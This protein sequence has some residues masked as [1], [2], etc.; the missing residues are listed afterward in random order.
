[1]SKKIVKYLLVFALLIFT[2]GIFSVIGL[3]NTQSENINTDIEAKADVDLS[4]ARNTND[5]V[6]DDV[7]RNTQSLTTVTKNASGT[8]QQRLAVNYTVKLIQN[9]AQLSE[10]AYKVNNGDSNE[11]TTN[12]VYFLTND[13]DLSG[14][15]WTP[16]G[17]AGKPFNA[18]F[19]G[20]GFTI[21]NIFINDL[22]VDSNA[23]SGS[24][25]FGNSTGVIANLKTSNVVDNSS[26]TKKSILC[27]VNNGKVVD[28][29]VN[30]T[31]T[32]TTVN[33]NGGNFKRGNNPWYEDTQL[34]LTNDSA[35]TA[36]FDYYQVFSNIKLREEAGL[37][38][39][40]PIRSGYKA[41]IPTSGNITWKATTINVTFYY[42][43]GAEGKA[44]NKSVDFGYDQTFYDWFS[45]HKGYNTRAG[46][47]VE[48]VYNTSTSG[49][50][51]NISDETDYKICY[52]EYA[53]NL[54]SDVYFTWTWANGTSTFTVEPIIAQT[55][56]DKITLSGAIKEFA[57][58]NND[59]KENPKEFSSDTATQTFEITL[60]NGYEIK[61]TNIQYSV[62]FDENNNN[63]VIVPSS[64]IYVNFST[65]TKEDPNYNS[66]GTNDNYNPISVSVSTVKK[67]DKTI[68]YTITVNNLVGGTANDFIYLAIQRR[69]VKVELID[70]YNE[71]SQ[72][73]RNI[74][75]NSG[76]IIVTY[77]NKTDTSSS[78]KTIEWS[79]TG[80]AGRFETEKDNN[81]N[82][83][84]YLV[85]KQNE[86]TKLKIESAGEN[87]YILSTDVTG[88]DTN[89][90]PSAVAEA[91]AI[92]NKVSGSALLGNS[93]E[94]DINTSSAYAD[95]ITEL[96]VNIGEAKTK[97]KTQ[98]YYGNAPINSFTGE[99]ANIS[100]KVN[101]S[102]D[103]QNTEA[104]VTR[105]T[106]EANDT[107]QFNANGFYQA[108][109]IVIYEGDAIGEEG[110]ITGTNPKSITFEPVSNNVLSQTNS[111]THHLTD[112]F[113]NE[114]TNYTIV[115]Y[116]E[117]R[118]YKITVTCETV[119][120]NNITSLFTQE[121]TGGAQTGVPSEAERT[122]TLTYKDTA[123]KILR[124]VDKDDGI[125]G[126]DK[127][128][129][130]KNT[131]SISANP[132]N[133]GSATISVKIGT[134]DANI[135]LKFEFKVVTINVS[136]TCLTSV[137]AGGLN[138]ETT[139]STDGLD[140]TT[141]GTYKFT[142]DKGKIGLDSEDPTK[143]TITSINLHSRYYAKGW[144]AG[145]TGGTLYNNDGFEIG[146]IPGLVDYIADKGLNNINRD[147]NVDDI[148]LEV[149]KRII[150]L[151][152]FSGKF[153]DPVVS[154]RG[155][156]STFVREDG[157]SVG[158][159]ESATII[160]QPPFK[161]L[162]HTFNG[163]KIII[164]NGGTTIYPNRTQAFADDNWYKVFELS[165]EYEEWTNF[166]YT[167][168][169]EK[170]LDIEALWN[171]I[172][173]KIQI[174]N[175]TAD[176][177][178]GQK[179][180]FGSGGDRNGVA[181]Y[182][183]EGQQIY[184]AEQAGYN[185]TSF[186]I[187][188]NTT[189]S[190]IT[191]YLFDV[192]NAKSLLKTVN[193]F[194][195]ND[196]D[197]IVITTNR[198]AA[199]FTITV[200]ATEEYYKLDGDCKNIQIAATFNEDVIIKLG[201]FTREGYTC[202]GLLYNGNQFGYMD[203]L[204]YQYKV[205]YTYTEDVF[206]YPTW[207][208]ISE[209]VESD[210]GMHEDAKGEVAFYMYNSL[211]V[212]KGGENPL[213]NT[214]VGKI[215]SNGEKITNLGFEITNH[216]GDTFKKE[217]TDILN[218]TDLTDSN[219]NIYA[220]EYKI[221]FFISVS[222]ILCKQSGENNDYVAES[223]EL[224]ITLIKNEL[225]FTGEFHSTY[226]GT[227]DF[228]VNEN[229]N[230]GA[231]YVKYGALGEFSEEERTLNEINPDLATKAYFKNFVILPK[232]EKFDAGVGYNIKA[233]FDKTLMGAY[234][235]GKNFEEL[236]SN[237]YAD[238]GNLYTIINGQTTIDKAK[239]TL[240]EVSS[241][242][243]YYFEGVEP[244]VYTNLQPHE[245]NIGNHTFAYSYDQIT[246]KS[247][248]DETLYGPGV[249][250]GSE[251]YQTDRQY[252]TIYNLK[253]KKLSDESFLDF[254]EVANNFEWNL[255]TSFSFTVIDSS[256]ETK[257]AKLVY[258]PKYILSENGEISDIL[259]DEFD[260]QKEILA[261]SDIKV[262]ATPVNNVGQSQFTYSVGNQV[263][264]SYVDNNT[265]RFSIY[266]NKEALTGN[267]LTFK[268]NVINRRN[269]LTVACWKANDTFDVEDLTNYDANDAYDVQTISNSQNV[270]VVMSDI[271][272]VNIDFNTGY[273]AHNYP[274]TTL[275][276]SSRDTYTILEE[277]QAITQPGFVFENPTPNYQGLAL[278]GY[279]GAMTSN[280][281]KQ[282]SE[283]VTIFN[284]TKGGSEKNLKAQWRFDSIVATQKISSMNAMASINS[285]TIEIRDIAEIAAFPAG[286]EV[287][288]TLTGSGLNFAYN[289][290]QEG[291][292][293]KNAQGLVP[294]SISGNYTL[295]IA[296]TYNENTLGLQRKQ[297]AFTFAYNVEINVVGIA[298]DE[299]FCLTFNDQN[300][301]E[302]V[303]IITYLN[304]SGIPT[305][306]NLLP[307]K[308]GNTG[309]YGY[310]ITVG[311]GSEIKN[312]GN[313]TLTIHV[314]SRYTEIFEI[315]E[316]KE[317]AIIRVLKYTILLRDYTD[318]I[319]LSKYYRTDDPELE[320]TLT[321][322][323]N[324]N[325]KVRISFTRQSGDDI[326]NYRLL[327]PAI[328][329]EGD[330]INYEIDDT[331]FVENFVVKPPEK[332]L[333]IR[334]KNQISYVYNGYK[335]EIGSANPYEDD[336]VLH[337]SA[338][339]QNF[340]IYFKLYFI[341]EE[342]V[343]G[344]ELLPLIKF[345]IDS[346]KH[347]GRYT[348]SVSVNPAAQGASDW[349]G[350]EI[351]N[352]EKANVIVS[353]KDLSVSAITK[354]FDRTNLITQATAVT[355]VGKVAG[356]DVN[357]DGTFDSLNV[358]TNITFTNLRL[359][360]SDAQNYNFTNPGFAGGIINQKY[361]NQVSITLNQN[362]VTYGKIS[363]TSTVQ[364]ILGF[365]NYSILIDGSTSDYNDGF[366]SVTG[367]TI[368]EE[369]YSSSN[370][371]QAGLRRI[372]ILLASDNFTGFNASGYEINL[373]ITKVRIDLSWV[374]IVKNY[375]T[376]NALPKI[377]NTD[378][379]RYILGVDDV[380][381]DKEASAYQTR[382]VGANIPVNLV[383]KGDDKNN[384]EI[385][386]NVRGRIN[387]YAV[388]LIVN[389]STQN[390]S[391]V[392]DGAFVD[393][394]EN[395]NVVKDVFA[396][397]FPFNRTAVQIIESLVY[398]TRAGY[399]AVGWKY[400][401]GEDFVLLTESNIEDYITSVALDEENV[402]STTTI[403]TAWEID[404]CDIVV[405]GDQ[406]KEY[407]VVG[408]KVSGNIDDGYKATYFSDFNIVVVGERGYKV[409]GILSQANQA[410]VLSL[411]ETG[412]T[413]G[414]ISVEKLTSNL[415]VKVLFSDIQITINFNFNKPQFAERIDSNS[416][417]GVYSYNT[418]KQLQKSGLPGFG[419]TNGTYHIEDYLYDNDKLVGEKFISEV[420]DELLPDLNKDEQISLKLQ[421]IGE[422][423]TILFDAQGGTIVG[424]EEVTAVYGQP[425]TLLPVAQKIGKS[426]VWADSNG[427]VY[428]EGDP[429]TS[430]G[431]KSSGEW[432]I[433]FVAQYTNNTY[434]LTI[435]I[436]PHVNVR[437]NG[438]LLTNGQNFDLVYDEDVLT[439]D[440]SAD[441][442]YGFIVDSALVDGNVAVDNN[443][444]TV[445]NLLAN[446]E[447]SFVATKNNNT[448]ELG[449]ANIA[450]IGVRILDE[451]NDLVEVVSPE[452]TQT[453]YTITAQTERKVE[454]TLT[455]VKGTA[456][457][458]N[459]VAF[460]GSGNITKT[461][462][463]F[464]KKLVIV[465]EGF[466]AGATIVVRVEYADNTVSFGD[467][468]NVFESFAINGNA[469]NVNGDNTKIKTSQE[470]VISATLKYGYKDAAISL[471]TDT[472]TISDESNTFNEVDRKYHYSVK[473]NQ[474]DDDFVLSFACEKR[475]YNFEIVVNE[476]QDGVGQITSAIQQSI[477]FGESIS[478]AQNLL[479]D[480]FIFA[481]WTIG[482]D[483]VS[484][485][486]S[487][488]IVIDETMARLIE[489]TPFGEDIRVQANYREKIA[490][491]NF[492]AGSR[493]SYDVVQGEDRFTVESS[494][495]VAR[496]VK[497][498][499]D[500][501]FELHSEDGYEFEYF[502]VDG[503]IQDESQ[504]ELED[505]V[506]TYYIPVE[507]AITNFKI[508]FKSSDAYVHVYGAILINYELN[509]FTSQGGKVFLADSEG[510]KVDSSVYLPVD[511][512]LEIGGNYR[513]LSKT[514]EKLY[515]VAEPKHG[516]EVI[517]ANPTRD[518]VLNQFTINDK[519]IYSFEGIKDGTVIEAIFTAKQNK[520][521]VVL[522]EEDG[523]S[524]PGGKIVVDTSSALVR[525]SG[526]NSANVNVTVITGET[527]NIVV[528]T[529][530]TYRFSLDDLGRVNYMFDKPESEEGE[531]EGTILTFTGAVTSLDPFTT[532]LTSR[533]ILQV[534][535][536]DC[537]A[538]LYIYV[539]PEK[540]NLRFLID[541]NTE[542]VVHDVLQYGKT[543][544]LSSLTPEQ[545]EI[546]LAKREGFT[547][548]G[549]Y[550]MQLGQGKK[551]VD[552][553][554]NPYAI[555]LETGYVFNGSQYE[556]DT[557]YN[558]LT[559]T[560]TIYPYWV[561]NKANVVVDTIPE[562]ILRNNPYISIRN[563][564]VNY[565]EQ[566]T[567]IS[568]SDLWYAQIK[569]GN[570]LRI[571]AYDLE[572]YAFKY[573]LVTVD[574]G[575]PVQRDR[576]FSIMLEQADYNL[577]AVYEPIFTMVVEDI[578][579]RNSDIG[580]A[581]LMQDGVTI[582]RNSYDSTKLVTLEAVAK[583]GYALLYFEDVDTGERYNAELN[584]ATGKASYT[585]AGLINRPL[586]LK[587]VFEGKPVEIKI[588]Y[589]E[590]A[591]YHQITRVTLNG[592]NVD[593]R[594]T[595][596]AKVGDEIVIEVVKSFGYS[597]NG[598]GANFNV[599]RS[600][601]NITLTAP[602]AVDSLTINQNGKYEMNIYFEIEK[603]EI[604]FNITSGVNDSQGKSEDIIASKVE[605]VY[606]NGRRINLNETST[607][608]LLYGE[609][610]SLN[611]KANKNYE[612]DQ[613]YI[614]SEYVYSIMYL[615][616]G[617]KIAI[618]QNFVDENVIEEN[619]EINIV[620]AF[621]R[622]VWNM[623][624]FRSQSIVGEGTKEKPFLIRSEADM[625]FVAYIVNSG[626]QLDEETKYADCY[627]E[628]VVDL[629]FDGKYFEP[630]GTKE[631]P[632][633]GVLDLGGY[634]IRNVTHYK[635]YTS[636]STQA[637]G[638]VWC[639]TAN[640]QIIQNNNVLVISLSV[641]GSGILAGGGITLAVILNRR[642]KRKMNANL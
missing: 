243:A 547:L 64:G 138:D 484:T 103:L 466:T 581:Y 27:G 387:E 42:N 642:K 318:Q 377:M 127:D 270:F 1:M 242:S 186:N 71:I 47:N 465:W 520:F 60:K 635:L 485:E 415:D 310:Y 184:S 577:I 311:E 544:S 309:E 6:V 217:K 168:K 160:D 162:G 398:P 461:L 570:Q 371:L 280:I 542:V 259:Y 81:N 638:L 214:S 477:L 640:A 298:R 365:V 314:D 213:T 339:T 457:A 40:Y 630:I 530:F 86:Q 205:N 464:N 73:T 197:K 302:N 68:K 174:D 475:Q 163:W 500:I 511:G 48:G 164:P 505:G 93:Y 620:V 175:H 70:N 181:K 24:G 299:E 587:A 607:F 122:I 584:Q 207:K 392:T 567:W 99:Y 430:V 46:Y 182:I 244:L 5:D 517:F 559:K 596:N 276:L 488:N 273:D 522:I 31:I 115:V 75:E 23:N 20:N 293:I 247:S 540:Y 169:N 33:G 519:T 337:C 136:K 504:F 191:E 264:F 405:S 69:D 608:K 271:V 478:V 458:D 226:T 233:D 237:I 41:T 228:V 506:I 628:L 360:G 332:I 351:D 574:G 565:N 209:T 344:G 220:G 516:F 196:S 36:K 254:G 373:D 219:N 38:N 515:F 199:Q 355:M 51:Y 434:T 178:I 417:S 190:Q 394:G 374:E 467:I 494:Q 404:E 341:G 50:K 296:A 111:S 503:T 285:Q 185:A 246:L 240:T 524:V 286:M 589:Q 32:S 549:Y 388:T 202:D 421:W 514:N 39:V 223:G 287:S 340:D 486:E 102:E 301:I 498:G 144:R 130:E 100:L 569:V 227:G 625:A 320:S 92:I 291:F 157:V 105:E 330:L 418:L 372:K 470:A 315:D 37:S 257:V 106:G 425:I 406:L 443:V 450:T 370:Y 420:V 35:L 232:E 116:I 556:Y 155:N 216:N 363:R 132:F 18:I 552:G 590:L 218:L 558:E 527:L 150:K 59:T 230:Y 349:E 328:M 444:V 508:T 414:I 78:P 627:Y 66:A 43:Y 600:Q 139:V 568:Q 402:D 557:N 9:A 366:I 108:Q 308:D 576:E 429:L 289:P 187:K 80:S 391:L 588:N 55:E 617:E 113:I 449:K 58:D 77:T 551:Y 622:L 603:E 399:H 518:C 172:T 546:V 378:I 468:S 526:N 96:R 614:I 323:E 535:N 165:E 393:D 436:D 438:M 447:I 626:M 342:G 76:K 409:N 114:G 403:F 141:S 188:H 235:Y 361:V 7:V 462:S 195:G 346:E 641:M 448:L 621:N 282:V 324:N 572:G 275:Y 312:A 183:I 107:Y 26:K 367:W 329:D 623:E 364:E 129:F 288:Y 110:V 267:N 523:T 401:D 250:E 30:W 225:V 433:T 180:E 118:S 591:Q 531:E 432:T 236:F 602:I 194:A 12:T 19:Y 554:I 555:W 479:N 637:K 615:Y 408:D 303:D 610:V 16:I 585:F 423:Y 221:K 352:P 300:Q 13:I 601:N 74:T 473:L 441:Q 422:N 634:N 269:A 256:D 167:N 575:A 521:N 321:I 507:T 49:T 17:T 460:S 272:K 203:N 90:P 482:G 513:I 156:W 553:Q 579:G 619:Y 350:A 239:F 474:I 594:H 142:Y 170:D 146:G 580:N 534:E 224:T 416:L 101:N 400:Q 306:L 611:I 245:F 125:I 15:Y 104:I 592:T 117:R 455:S 616:D 612:L 63:K 56:N 14:E 335:L 148:Y 97:I 439:L 583:E 629:D 65:K 265:S 624:Q 171:E 268:V 137:S 53:D 317:S 95:Y 427:K 550:T 161:R 456:F 375:D 98:F 480:S 215:T 386:D 472:V 431:Q 407:Q 198:E 333:L 279:Q 290:N 487:D 124:Y 411:N 327:T 251:N 632:F 94:M 497:I 454:I 210:I 211:N 369:A 82:I 304:G 204:T 358:G 347:V 491:F 121:V 22:S 208:R 390:E 397:E 442:G 263:I 200:L 548:D 145:G 179:V 636:P 582:S 319:N 566:D 231:F 381:L 618:N 463:E 158:Y 120:G 331:D 437:F 45:S 545:R 54:T 536:V 471:S 88:R 149:G 435:N 633:N 8:L 83:R 343:V 529:G 152:Y 571:R 61:T 562:N 353:Q 294:T 489:R 492:E 29:N 537:D 153:S 262:N 84:V 25:L 261:I 483:V 143:D 128:G 380:M 410:R 201:R 533:T 426:S 512:V 440:V 379:S 499:T 135:V 413:S 266:V 496:Q 255:P 510:N 3:N 541:N 528:S 176:I 140:G 509:K 639:V 539:I 348:L 10:L 543:F 368:N 229:N 131:V 260:G 277:G 44:R 338:G 385:V 446:S 52:P 525:A 295:T 147:F 222:D 490:T 452:T 21:S 382:D 424:S 126:E 459:L 631:N 284:V 538:T 564:I 383:L 234:L 354:T 62:E 560:F 345:G 248:E 151:K 599:A 451:N 166:T 11:N 305:T 206:V 362:Q 326:G 252:F 123:E 481:S 192:A 597:F 502:F 453:S 28:C 561:Y 173:Y 445:N 396:I 79:I 241:G 395:V 578:D 593:Y 586:N 307:S 87:L 109:K 476:E 72:Y 334:L 249:Y 606:E 238:G 177:K 428:S 357:I 283:Q 91:L 119:E 253:I 134:Y 322:E 292:E 34:K 356:D 412:K 604:V 316:N 4:N 419:V 384:Y 281:T 532:G 493:G 2:A 189:V 57:G 359:V 501:K 258:A 573:W 154:Y 389:A 605:V 297:Q 609:A 598:K 595:V 89:I 159:G 112:F 67:A 336:Y 376:T 133:D 212:M 193:Y 85:L 313:Y 563:V 469:L 278:A 495:S 325:D 274:N 613:I